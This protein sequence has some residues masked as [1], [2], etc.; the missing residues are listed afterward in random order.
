[1]Q[2]LPQPVYSIHLNAR[3]SEMEIWLL[4]Q[5]CTEFLTQLTLP[6]KYSLPITSV[7]SPTC[8]SPYSQIAPKRREETA[9]QWLKQRNGGVLLTPH[10]LEHKIVG[11]KQNVLTVG[12][13]WRGQRNIQMHTHCYKQRIRFTFSNTVSVTLSF[14]CVTPRTVSLSWTTQ[15]SHL[16][17]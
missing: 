17:N 12:V 2:F 3:L 13:T 1:M 14:L 6:T 4:I 5:Q 8:F 9:G 16:L 15:T 10:L 7:C 11:S